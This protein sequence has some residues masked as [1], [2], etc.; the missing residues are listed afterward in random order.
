MDKTFGASL[1]VQNGVPSYQVEDEEGRIHLLLHLPI[2]EESQTRW[3]LWRPDQAAFSR[4]IF[5]GRWLRNKEVGVM[6]AP[7]T[8]RVAMR[9]GDNGVRECWI[10]APFGELHPV[11]REGWESLQRVHRRA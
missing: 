8:L 2:E 3:Y 1:R 10:T 4:S 7:A 9:A 5:D 6:V 11:G